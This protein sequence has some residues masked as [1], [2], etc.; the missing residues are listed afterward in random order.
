MIKMT[1]LLIYLAFLFLGVRAALTG[2]I[3]GSIFFG[4]YCGFESLSRTIDYWPNLKQRK[5]LLETL[6]TERNVK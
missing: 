3:A 2:D 5:E 1:G 4:L 6:K